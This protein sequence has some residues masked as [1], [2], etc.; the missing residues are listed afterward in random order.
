MQVMKINSVTQKVAWNYQ[1][2]QYVDIENNPDQIFLNMKVPAI[3]HQDKTDPNS[4]YL[5]GQFA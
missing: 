1:Y 4:M 5:V 3:L 2:F